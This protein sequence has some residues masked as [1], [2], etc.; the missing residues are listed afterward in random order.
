M[1][2]VNLNPLGNQFTLRFNVLHKPF[3]NPKVRQ[4]VFHAA[5]QEDYPKAVV[6]DSAY[7]KLCKSFFPCGSPFSS[8]TTWN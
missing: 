3:D 5:A 1:K 6:G 7:Y 4:A 8:T 2:L